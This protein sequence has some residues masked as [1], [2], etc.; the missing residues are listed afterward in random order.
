MLSKNEYENLQRLLTECNCTYEELD[1]R[2]KRKGAIWTA[3]SQMLRQA[4]TKEMILHDV[5]SVVKDFPKDRFHI[6]FDGIAGF[7]IVRNGIQ[8]LSSNFYE[9]E[10]C[11]QDGYDEFQKRLIKVINDV[12]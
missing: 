7:A 3:Y 6:E 8:L 12:S 2:V 11:Y 9:V 5:A 4:T 1:P 10:H